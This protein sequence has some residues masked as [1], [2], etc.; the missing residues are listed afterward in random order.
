MGKEKSLNY[1]KSLSTSI[2]LK[3]SITALSNK[4]SASK[5][6]TYSAVRYISLRMAKISE[7]NE[8]TVKNEEL[9]DKSIEDK[10]IKLKNLFDKDLITKSEY[11]QKKKTFLDLL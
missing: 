11:E 2:D 6:I 3:K 9:D 1:N 8:I 10:L 4:T 5:Q 7:T